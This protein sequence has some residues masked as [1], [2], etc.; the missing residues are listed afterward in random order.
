MGFGQ[1]SLPKKEQHMSEIVNCLIEEGVEWELQKYKE[2][3]TALSVPTSYNVWR[4][5][6]TD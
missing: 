6:E 1:V 2:N 3:I 5:N 4:S